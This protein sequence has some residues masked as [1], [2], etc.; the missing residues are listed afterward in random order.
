VHLTLPKNI[1]LA[2]LFIRIWYPT[3]RLFRQDRWGDW[4]GVFSRVVQALREQARRPG[5]QRVAVQLSW[6]NSSNAPSERKW[7]TA[8]L[9][10]ALRLPPGWG[11]RHA[12]GRRTGQQPEGSP[13]DTGRTG[14]RDV[15]LEATPELDSR[16]TELLRRHLQAKRQRSSI[17]EQFTTWLAHDQVSPPHLP[18]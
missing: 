4:D 6:P 5:L 3:A 2:T 9:A 10:R 17:L 14:Q 18:G 11:P 16:A 13:P 1:S 8:R 12:R 15:A 7:S